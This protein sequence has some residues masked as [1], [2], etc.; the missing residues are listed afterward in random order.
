MKLAGLKRKP[1]GVT[2]M[3]PFLNFDDDS[4]LI[5]LSVQQEPLT[6]VYIVTMWMRLF[7]SQW[8]H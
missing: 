1:V 6:V 2:V 7:N 3:S 8:S 4:V 5:T